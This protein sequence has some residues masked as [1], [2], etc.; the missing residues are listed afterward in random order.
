M[1]TIFKRKSFNPEEFRTQNP[2]SR[3]RKVFLFRLMALPDL[4]V[5]HAKL[6]SPVS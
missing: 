2:E 6:L 5:R 4:K 3:I 1:Q